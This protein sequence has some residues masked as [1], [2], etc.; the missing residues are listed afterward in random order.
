[1][2]A[3]IKGFRFHDL[4]HHTASELAMQGKPLHLIGQLLGHKSYQTTMKYAHLSTATIDELGDALVEIY[5]T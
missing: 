3:G 1:M 4:R 2:K 5:S